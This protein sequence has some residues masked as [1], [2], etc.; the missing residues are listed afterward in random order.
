MDQL[1]SPVRSPADQTLSQS[2]SSQEAGL[3][4]SASFV[5]EHNRG[6]L[7]TTSG[8]EVATP[9]SQLG[10]GSSAEGVDAK[11]SSPTPPPSDPTGHDRLQGDE[12][13]TSDPPSPAIHRVNP[14]A[15]Q[16]VIIHSHGAD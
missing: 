2:H 13:D 8:S 4:S 16:P 5:D 6:L 10:D 12:T 11:T 9:G 7:Q 1:C 15:G 3:E 14:F